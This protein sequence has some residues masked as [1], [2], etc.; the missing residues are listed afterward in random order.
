MSRDYRYLLEAGITLGADFNDKTVRI[1]VSLCNEDDSYS[2]ETGKQIINLLFDASDATL[3][4]LSLT[5]NVF[6]FPYEGS[7]LRKDILAPLVNFLHGEELDIPEDRLMAVESSLYNL[8]DSLKERELQR[9]LKTALKKTKTLA[10]IREFAEFTNN[11]NF[12]DRYEEMLEGLDEER[13][14]IFKS[15]DSS[16]EIFEIFFDWAGSAKA[17]IN[18]VKK[19]AAIMRV[20]NFKN[21][22]SSK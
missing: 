11:D 13:Q 7:K 2:R 8:Y 19:F 20:V 22:S 5:R 12:I 14:E 3:R 10:A 15:A 4:A 1:A 6:S 18:S 17:I 9:F 21:T 16:E